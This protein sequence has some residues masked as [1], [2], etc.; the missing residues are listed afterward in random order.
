MRPLRSASISIALSLA[1]A[2]G[3][4]VPAQLPSL[5]TGDDALRERARAAHVLNRLAFGPRPGDVD[6]VLTIGVDR[7]IERQLRPESTLDSAGTA[8]LR[9]CELWTMPVPEALARLPVGRRIPLAGDDV[10]PDG[11]S[12]TVR[13][14]AIIDGLGPIVTRESAYASPVGGASLDAGQLLA[15][16]LARVEASDQQL[17]EV[18][19]DFWE[20]HFSL[21]GPRIPSGGS[22]VEWDRQV[23]RPNALGRFRT[24]LG[25]VAHSPAMLQYLDNAVNTADGPN[26]NYARELLEL[27]TLGVDGGYTQADVIDVA[28]AFTGWTHTTAFLTPVG[29]VNSPQL[30]SFVFDSTVHDRRPK[31]VL[32]R[33][34][35]AGRGIQD[36]NDVLYLL[37][38]H[39]STARFIARKLAVRFVSDAPSDSLVERAAETFRRTGGDIRE[40]VRTIVTS[41]EF[42]SPAT[43]RAKVKSPQELVLSLRRVLMA[44]SDT[45]AETIDVLIGLDQAPLSKVSPEGWPETGAGWMT[46]GAMLARIDLANRIAGGEVPSIP[47]ER[48]PS[49]DALVDRP[50]DEQVD[51]VVRVLLN[52]QAS[53]ETR[54][55]LAGIRPAAADQDTPAARRRMLRS[56]VAL[57]L[58]SPEFQRR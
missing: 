33:A 52:G 58:S 11:R 19:T 37:A 34:L 3:I 47:I 16:R 38:E 40:V 42:M 22:F 4:P 35:P 7:W 2:F 46:V 31:Q 30:S 53:A 41:A 21:F 48:W 29:R 26:E 51:G 20:N 55:A 25:A 32:G 56:L 9:G 10:S 23:I 49:W 24:L 13:R 8:A 28:R 36:G 54:S 1:S 5:E 14:F 15:C 44:P 27:H 18:M 57:A 12:M 17:L 43:H 50:Y 39:P 45:G 6:R